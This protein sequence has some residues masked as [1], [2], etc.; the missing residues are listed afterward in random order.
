MVDEYGEI[1]GLVTLV[2][3]LEEIVGEFTTTVNTGKI[4]EK[5]AD[6]SYLVEGAITLRDLNRIGKF[7]F[8]TKGP[9]TLNGLITEHLEMIPKVGVCVLIANYPIEIVEMKGN[10]VKVARV[11]PR[12]KPASLND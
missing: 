3:I 1:L 7:K 8:S 5:Q 2:D 12:L 4:I 9:R 10:Q 6:N 11:F